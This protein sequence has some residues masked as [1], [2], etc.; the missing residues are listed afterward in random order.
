[1]TAQ[2][3]LKALATTKPPHA[4]WLCVAFAQSM[5]QQRGTAFTETRAPRLGSRRFAAPRRAP[6]GAAGGACRH[7]EIARLDN[8]HCRNI[9]VLSDLQARSKTHLFLCR[10]DVGPA[11]YMPL[12][13]TPTSR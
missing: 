10:L 6:D 13:Y 7:D 1:M 5:T 3:A 9:L 8:D 11:T 4:Y 12:V 2:T